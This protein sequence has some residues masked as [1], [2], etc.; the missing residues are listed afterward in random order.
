MTNKQVCA[1]CLNFSVDKI[2]K[3]E[4]KLKPTWLKDTDYVREFVKSVTTFKN[5]VPDNID[6]SLR[7]ELG[8]NREKI[9]WELILQIHLNVIDACKHGKF[10]NNGIATVKNGTA[11][12]KLSYPSLQSSKTL[13]PNLFHFK[14]FPLCIVFT[15]TCGTSIIHLNNSM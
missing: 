6:A 3:S 8:K 4:D 2:V 11:L 12:I 1:S 14:T 15:R 10:Q 13:R 9:L 5:R 7:L